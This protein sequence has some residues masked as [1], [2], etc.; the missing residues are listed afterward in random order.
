MQPAPADPE[1]AGALARQL[2]ESTLPPLPAGEGS[3]ALAW[4]LKD[5]CYEAW[6]GAPQRAVRAAE[7]LRQLLA[8]GVPATQQREIE[9]LAAWTAGIACAT[10]AQMAEAVRCFDDAAAALREAGRPDP[11]A[12]TQVPKIMALSMLGQHA[13]AADC[14]QA[15]QRELR[16][17]GNLRAA[18]RVS[19][20]LGSLQLRRDAYGEAARHYREAAVLFAR[21]GDR[22]H[23]VLAD[24]GMADAFTSLGDFEEALR[25][26]ARA[27]MRAGLQGMELQQGL[28]DESVALLELTRGHYRQALSGFESARRR[29]EA[30]SLPQYLAVAEKQLADAYL[31]LRLLPEALALFE[32]AVNQFR[33]LAL[34]DE[35]AWALAQQGR[36][37]ALLG[38]SAADTSFAAATALFQAQG[39]AV[40]AAAVALA[41]AELALAAG[42]ADIALGWADEAARGF[43]DAAQAD[44]SA[45]AEVLQAQA[46]LAGGHIAEAG[47]AFDAAL[48]RAREQQRL[49]VQVRCLTGQG[50]TAL[51]R[52]EPATAA[53]AFEAAIELFEDQRRALPGDEIRSAFLTD[54]LRPYQEQLRLALAQ[55]DGAQTLRQ[56]DR[57]RARTL[58]E[59]QLE[60]PEGIG[61]D[62]EQALRDRLNWLYR[63]VQRLQDEGEASAA[64]TDEMQR[65][66]AELLERTRRRRLAAPDHGESRAAPAPGEFSVSA[67]QAALA[68]G[69]VLVEYGALDDEL[70]ACVVTHDAVHQVR[71]LA[72]WSEVLEAVQ[73]V[74]F[75]MDTLR[76][77][78]A[79]VQRHLPV[80]EARARARLQRVHALVWQP[81]ATALGP[82]LVEARRVLIV[83]HAGLGG[84]PFAALQD[85][86]TALG[87]RHEL[88]MAP[89]AR[90]ALRGL[91]Q[92]PAAARSA[93]AVG[94]S[95]RLPH[96][97]AEATAV[98]ALF[99][100]GR[101]CVGEQATL[102]QLRR[103]APDADVLHLACHAQFRG[104]NP[105]FS[106]LHLH[107]GV[108]T[109]DMAEGLALRPG[110]VVLSA[111]ETAL[112]D[113]GGGDEMFGL[114]RA[115][116]VAGASRVLASQWPVDDQVTARFMA[117]FYD[118]VVQGSGTAQALQRAQASLMSEHSHPYFWSAFSLYGGW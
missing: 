85:G 39:N 18:A 97:G 14:A 59:R 93:L 92:A 58:D 21:L 78:A 43:A 94:E 16:A 70:F 3:L 55:G 65:T 36:A 88:A 80:L 31:E 8:V 25:I 73:S 100:H 71:R 38:R 63:R 30:L 13:Q 66:E 51:A 111:C 79:P 115:F 75:Q 2:L 110:I 118:E 76:H 109:V 81:L 62:E 40:G 95:S 6:T 34:P 105:R 82:A 84:L 19:Q 103:F 10:Q 47:A 102:E 9:G 37:Q 86:D 52:G 99:D 29:Y 113:G 44:G 69:D 101:A 108:L 50:Q 98:A 116:L 87:Q 11:A 4:A 5:L 49:T 42:D 64:L 17:L 26:Y 89:S 48:L 61:D 90:A 57:F 24:I 23:S 15:T 91:R 46:L 74:R 67:L 54:S 28:V 7:L 20:N 112:A 12:Q 22:E 83:P 45:R 72:P 77:G 106:A 32:A 60:G 27:R 107:D 117:A 114:V 104:D 33:H 41:R 68:D 1:A 35:Q 53:A 56:L 96:A